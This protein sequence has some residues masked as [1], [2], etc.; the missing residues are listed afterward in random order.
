MS[1]KI[2]AV[3]FDMGGTLRT[4]VADATH[5][6]KGFSELAALLDATDPLPVFHERLL[7]RHKAYKRWAEETMIEAPE[8][9]IWTIWMLPDYPAEQII[10]LVGRL[11]QL[12]RQTQGRRVV[13]PDARLVVAELAR[14]GYQLGVVSN[15]TSPDVVPAALDAYGLAAYFPVVVLSSTFGRRKPDPTIFW[16]ATHRLKVETNQCAYVGDQPSRD[17]LGSQRAGFALSILIEDDG[18]TRNGKNNSPP[19]PDMT[20]RSLSQLLNIL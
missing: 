9:E 7:Q 12:W 1:N 15:T 13:R 18:Q 2:E 4:R 8:T 14:R 20:I 5:Q 11:T 19:K 3:L 6:Q 17:V 10:P 16:E